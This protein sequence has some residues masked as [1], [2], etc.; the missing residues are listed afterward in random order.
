MWLNASMA[1]KKKPKIYLSNWAS[2]KA[3]GCHG[4]G[5]LL[6]IMVR[7]SQFA[8]PVGL[9]P[10]LT[11]RKIDLVE[12]KEGKIDL[13]EYRLRYLK[14]VPSA[15][16]P[17]KLTWEPFSFFDQDK[18]QLVE[19]GDTLCCACSREKAVNGECHRVWAATLLMKA[20]WEVVLDGK[21]AKEIDGPF[22]LREEIDNTDYTA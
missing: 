14:S 17:G 8:S 9:V 5:H 22:P 18:V 2:H 7:T 3:K 10:A 1:K 20:G 11:P 15:L 4:P 13:E 12:Y 19:D 6:S 16:V 21:K